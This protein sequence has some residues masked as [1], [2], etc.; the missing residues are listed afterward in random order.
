MHRHPI[1]NRC[2]SSC[3]D[4]SIAMLNVRRHDV[5]RNGRL[6]GD[7]VTDGVRV[8]DPKKSGLPDDLSINSILTI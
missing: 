8:F 3:G 4:F 6:Y 1:H 7:E 5:P 2:D